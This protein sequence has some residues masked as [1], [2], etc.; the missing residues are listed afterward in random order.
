MK[1]EKDLMQEQREAEEELAVFMNQ[2]LVKEVTEVRSTAPKDAVQRV[3][4]EKKCGKE[5]LC[6][7]L[8]ELRAARKREAKEEELKKKEAVLKLKEQDIHEHHVKVFD[9]TES[10]GLGLLNEMS[11][12]ETKVRLEANERKRAEAESA[13]RREILLQRA[14]READLKER[15]ESIQA[16]RAAAKQANREAARERKE[17]EA[18][19]A[20]AERMQ[21]ER[22]SIALME[23]LEIKRLAREAE[24]AVLAEEEERR[25]KAALYL[26][27]AAAA[28][29]EKN[30]QQMLSG[31][32]REAERRQRVAR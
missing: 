10:A 20:E 5:K 16:R 21:R 23:E 25:T 9:P 13:R 3:L 24:M 19:Q 18:A 4:D 7:E 30:F 12:V 14:K 31:A 29:E 32:E 2:R 6:K 28:V 26:G 15:L 22:N 1:V 17:R 11:L 8:E 27:R